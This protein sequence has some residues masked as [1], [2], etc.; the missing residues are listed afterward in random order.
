MFFKFKSGWKPFKSNDIVK[1]CAKLSAIDLKKKL[2][3]PDSPRIPVDYINI[4]KEII[5]KIDHL[6]QPSWISVYGIEYIRDL[7]VYILTFEFIYITENNESFEFKTKIKFSDS[8][9]ED[10]TFD[11]FLKF[12][13]TQC[14]IAYEKD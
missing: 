2:F 3:S 12:L 7:S 8:D 14:G 9:V 6:K 11:E 1:I 10:L 13:K 5:D 4:R